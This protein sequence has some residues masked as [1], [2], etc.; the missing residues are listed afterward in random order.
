VD[1]TDAE[2]WERFGPLLSGLSSA[3]RLKP[4]VAGLISPSLITLF[5]EL[6]KVS[7]TVTNYLLVFAEGPLLSRIDLATKETVIPKLSS[8][9]IHDTVW[10]LVGVR[11]C[12]HRAA[13][14]A[15]LYRELEARRN[16]LAPPER[17]LIAV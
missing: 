10:P 9:V 17:L 5:G 13:Y 8:S 15:H 2:Y 16:T 6:T 7:S 4:L 3:A 1:E 12:C 14:R 11:V